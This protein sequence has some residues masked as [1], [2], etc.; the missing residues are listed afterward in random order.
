[1][2]FESFAVTLGTSDTLVYRM[3]S[4]TKTEDGEYAILPRSGALRIGFYNSDSSA[5]TATI[6]VKTIFDQTPVTIGTISL[7]AGE[8][9]QWPVPVSLGPGDYMVAVGSAASQIVAS[10]SVAASP[11]APQTAA[12]ETIWTPFVMRRPIDHTIAWAIASRTYGAAA[13]G[14]YFAGVID[15]VTGTIDAADAYQT[16]QRFALLVG[17][18]THEVMGSSV[19]WDSRAASSPVVTG[20][21]TRW[22]GLAATA[23][24]VA[25]GA[26][27]TE[28]ANNVN[29][30]N[31]SDPAPATEGGSVWYLPALDELELLYRNLKPNAA[32][33]RTDTQAYNTAQ[34]P[35][36]AATTHGVNNSSLP[37]G[38][39]YANNPRRPDETPLALFKAGGSQTLSQLYYWSST[40][41]DATNNPRAW[42]QRFTASGVE[43]SQVTLTKEYTF[44]SVRSVRRI[45]F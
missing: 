8:T 29:A 3:P 6:K 11:I 32:N 37:A 12:G 26:V 36:T 18:K 2:S 41:A 1:M 5:R 30:R 43:G 13:V 31:S 38:V 34:F 42:F 9:K 28:A 20:A 44:L 23:A 15:T 4:Y 35:T 22:D 24:I 45:V 19:Q 21:K 33:N 7:D 10:G 40:E 16:G 14:G 27:E 39:A 17:P 25:L